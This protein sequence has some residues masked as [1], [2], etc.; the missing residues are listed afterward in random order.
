MFTPTE[1][2]LTCSLLNFDQS[3]SAVEE[4]CCIAQFHFL[5]LDVDSVTTRKT[6]SYARKKSLLGKVSLFSLH[7]ITVNNLLDI[8]NSSMLENAGKIAYFSFTN[9][10]YNKTDSLQPSGCN[11]PLVM[12]S[13][14]T[15]C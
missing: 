13:N 7:L 4:R 8:L 2:P 14:D 15:F 5:D 9:E 1:V 6:R 10:K 3:R 12:T 11:G